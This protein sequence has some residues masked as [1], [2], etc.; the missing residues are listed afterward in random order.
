MFAVGDLTIKSRIWRA[1]LISVLGFLAS[2]KT[3]AD[4]K[5]LSQLFEMTLQELSAVKIT[6]STLQDESL[7]S[8]PS[9]VT[10][11][12]K[13]DIRR[14]GFTR[15][16][17]LMNFV[18]GFQ[19]YRSDSNSQGAVYSSRGRRTGT[20][21][22]EV[23]ILLDG[24]RL[25]DDWAGG[26]ATRES[27]IPLDNVSRV[28]FIRGPGSSIYGSN[29]FLGVINIITE[30][31]R[32]FTV[33]AGSEQFQSIAAQWQWQQQGKGYSIFVKDEKTDGQRL[34]LYDADPFVQ[35]E[36][37]SHDPYEQRNIYLSAY[38]D[39]FKI[40]ALLTDS[41][42]EEF[43]IEG[44]VSNDVNR[45]DRE[46]RYFDLSYEKRLDQQWSIK[47]NIF[48]IDRRTEITGVPDQSIN[49]VSLGRV[50]EEDRG[51]GLIARYNDGYHAKGVAGIE[52]RQ[53]N[54]YDTSART[55]SPITNMVNLAPEGHRT[56]RGYFGQYQYKFDDKWEGILGVRVDNYSDFGNHISP[57]LGLTYSL[58]NTNTIKWLYGEA[59][60]APSRIE[61]ES[62][63]NPAFVGN[64]DLQP[65]ISR[66]LELVWS[67]YLT[68]GFLEISM[69]GVWIDDSIRDANTPAPKQRINSGDE[70][71]AGFEL[72]W[73]Q[74]FLHNWDLRTALTWFADEAS[75]TNSESDLLLAA[76][77]HYAKSKWGF[78][79][80]MNYQ[81][82]KSDVHDSSLSSQGYTKFDSWT[83]FSA[84]A[85]YHFRKNIE[86]YLFIDNLFDE[87]Y[88][89]PA[90]YQ[91]NTAGVPNKGVYGFLGINW[92][93]D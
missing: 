6:G 5:E 47:T 67:R 20:S 92:K 87:E 49:L 75:K 16:D 80:N 10:V 27:L 15:L 79:L 22:R 43:Y 29:A 37:S 12:E 26:A 32:E 30:G 33:T 23:L 55:L 91:A 48:V 18:P 85:S 66:T 71:I 40:K 90:G 28:E 38:A 81:S 42:N 19:S 88:V 4:E 59:F 69:F 3:I 1:V 25:N 54:L 64:P 17:Q 74:Q 58:D 2:F 82:A 35:D 24:F 57:R 7:Q 44:F 31:D 36:I 52:Y 68:R 41:V 61:T 76:S 63:N 62:I 53:P 51:F 45:W 8:V 14:M 9:S 77:L 60:R 78:A 21:A 86:A 34:T 50:F 39:N 89:T 65:E 72:E 70:T 11:F 56:I 83:V 13:Q 73:Q 84:K 46:N 93:F